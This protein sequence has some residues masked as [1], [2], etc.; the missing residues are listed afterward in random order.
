MPNK[1][2][3]INIALLLAGEEEIAD[4]DDTSKPATTAKV[5]WD[6]C[7]ESLISR[8]DWSWAV[9]LVT[10][11]PDTTP[12]EFGYTQRFLLPDDFNHI[13]IN[14]I[15]DPEEE[16]FDFRIFGEYLHFSGDSL[17]LKYCSNITNVINMGPM[18]AEAL[19]YLLAS[20]IASA[21]SSSPEKPNAYFESLYNGR[22]ALAIVQDPVAMGITYNTT[23]WSDTR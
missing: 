17:E 20:K 8:A 15:E 13:V 23:A 7:L 18:A 11:A 16:E 19:S 10:L 12:P 6:L 4:L 21:L 5:F 1:T 9:S 22:L 14:I 3:I 2:D